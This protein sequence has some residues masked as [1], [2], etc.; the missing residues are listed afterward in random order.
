VTVNAKDVVALV[1]LVIASE[2]VP[3]G[4]VFAGQLSPTS[5]VIVC[6]NANLAKSVPSGSVTTGVRE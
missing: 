2:M 6:V 4:W 1:R 5:M 3:V